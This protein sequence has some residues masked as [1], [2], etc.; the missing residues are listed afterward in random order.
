MSAL[1]R[2]RQF[3]ICALVASTFAA[4]GA[5]NEPKAPPVGVPQLVDTAEQVGFGVRT[6]LTANGV[7]KGELQADTMY[8]YNDQTKFDFRNAHVKFN[9]ETG[10][11]N[12]TLRGDR[13]TYDLHSQ[14]LDGYG[15]VVVT[16]TDGKRLLSNHLKYVQSRNEI[17]SDSAFTFYRQPEILTEKIG[18]EAASANARILFYRGNVL[19]DVVLDRT[20]AMSAAELRELATDLPEPGGNAMNPPNLPAYLPRQGLVRNST[21]YV[22]GPVGLSEI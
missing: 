12:G 18:S 5:C 1:L 22:M 16:S 15:N 3:G 9:T 4:T 6:L 13:G 17:S 7:Q 21:K 11:P 14:T 19:V 2:V 8:V 10:A 20:T